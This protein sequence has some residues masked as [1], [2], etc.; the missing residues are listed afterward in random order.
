[1]ESDHSDLLKDIAN[2]EFEIYFQ[3][4]DYTTTNLSYLI[5]LKVNGVIKFQYSSPIKL[6]LLNQFQKIKYK[7]LFQ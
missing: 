7:N 1:V 3:L 5:L 4:C 2:V 6:V